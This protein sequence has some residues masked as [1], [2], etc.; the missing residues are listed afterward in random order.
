MKGP[1]LQ[2]DER[3]VATTRKICTRLYLL[4]MFALWLDVC[5]RQFILGQPLSEFIDLAALTAANI[6]L[7]VGAVLVCGGVAVRKI[8]A[9]AVMLFYGVCVA[10]GAVLTILKYQLNSVREILLRILL[11][12]AVSGVVVILYVAAA[13]WSARKANRQIEE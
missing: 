7:F 4:T 12:A 6:F 5:W 8:R 13:Y 2:T 3:T 1:G 9:S 10:A 11:V